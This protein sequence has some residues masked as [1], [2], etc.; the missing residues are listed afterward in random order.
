MKLGFGKAGLATAVLMGLGLIGTVPQA[1]AQS[2]NPSVNKTRV[3]SMNATV[4]DI[5]HAKR[6]LTLRG[7]DGKTMSV[8]AGEDVKNF[9]QIQKG[10]KVHASYYESLAMTLRKPGEKA[11]PMGTSEQ[12][13]RNSMGGR[14]A[15]TMGRKTTS[16]VDVVSVD[17]KG[18]SI[19]VRDQEGNQHNLKVN[20]P[21]NQEKLGKIKAGDHID[22]TYTEALAISVEPMKTAEEPK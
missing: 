14:P 11:P 9:D 22:V 2:S 13:E 16:T 18:H 21:A 3:T 15:G 6:T 1:R 4:E 20:D 7:A 12:A 17:Q 5:D 19:V 10:D 8:E